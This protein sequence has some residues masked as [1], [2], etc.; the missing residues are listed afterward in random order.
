MVLASAV[1]TVDSVFLFF[2]AAFMLM[3]VA[4]FILMEMR[5]SQRAAKFQARHSNDAH[6]HRHLAFSLARATP[7]LVLMI[8]V[9]AAAVF[10]LL[11]RMS[12]A[13]WA[14]IPTA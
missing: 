12:A 2:F 4:T 6:E 8:L 9:G 10:F 3:G 11:P 7:L 1:L 14:A 13:I 5:R